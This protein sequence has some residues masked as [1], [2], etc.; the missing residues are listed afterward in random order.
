MSNKRNKIV[1]DL[2]TNQSANAKA[3]INGV[4]AKCNF[5]KT[6]HT[7]EEIYYD[8]LQEFIERFDLDDESKSVAY[9][10]N[11]VRLF[12]K[13]YVRTQFY[14]SDKRDNLKFLNECDYTYTK[15]I[16][17]F[18][19]VS[20]TEQH[21]NSQI[22]CLCIRRA[23]QKFMKSL[24]R[25]HRILAKMFFKEELSVT[26]VASRLNLARSYTSK[27]KS[28]LSEQAKHFL[29]AEGVVPNHLTQ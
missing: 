11:A 14:D 19:N 12:T 4:L 26:E 21:E 8:F 13:D 5:R 2:Y 18:G 6:D 1:E 25:P 10:H 17:D 23:H 28:K 3:I 9:F 29:I 7:V 24:S 20:N 15:K 22:S 16:S 27:L